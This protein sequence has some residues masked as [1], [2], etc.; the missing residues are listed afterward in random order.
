MTL[1]VIIEERGA[2]F[3]VLLDCVDAGG[4]IFCAT[5]YVIDVV[6]FCDIVF[7]AGCTIFLVFVILM[8]VFYLVLFLVGL[9][10]VIIVIF[11]WYY[12]GLLL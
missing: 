6:Y 8:G 3:Q 10:V 5:A 12:G 4:V 2:R 11:V 7:Y 1:C 9:W